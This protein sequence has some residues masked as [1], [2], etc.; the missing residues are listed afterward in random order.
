MFCSISEGAVMWGEFGKDLSETL[1]N[2]LIA[3]PFRRG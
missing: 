2:A 1:E 3:F